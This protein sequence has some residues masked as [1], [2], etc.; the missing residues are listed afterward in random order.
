MKV[1]DFIENLKKDYKDDDDILFIYWDKKLCRE[2]VE[3]M[4]DDLKFEH[5][6]TDNQVNEMFDNAWEY[7]SNDNYNTEE[8]GE[9]I[10]TSLE[11]SFKEWVSE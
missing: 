1:K 6:L 5:N 3:D 9:A 8:V 4:L 2:W 7:A 10:T 11:E